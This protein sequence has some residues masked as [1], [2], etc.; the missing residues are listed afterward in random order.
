M[1]LVVVF[2][3]ALLIAVLLS[4][5]AAR[6]VLSTGG[7]V[8]DPQKVPAANRRRPRSGTGPRMSGSRIEGCLMAAGTRP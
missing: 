6:T 7:R 4:G 5:L 3:V 8:A 2:G 1:V